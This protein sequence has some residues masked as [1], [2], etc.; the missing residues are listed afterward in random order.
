MKKYTFF[1]ILIMLGTLL[2]LNNC[3]TN[4]A[5]GK[6]SFTAFMSREDEIRIGTE[7]HPRLIK[8]FGGIYK[9]TRL[10]AYV[11]RVGLKLA[12][13]ADDSG[14]KYT[15]TILNSEKVNALA[16][17]GGFIYITR[18]LLA[19][20][21]NEAELAG[22]LAHEIGHVTARHT[23]ERYST[24]KATNLG[25]M[26]LN[27]LS[28]A[29]GVPTG[30][31]QLLGFGAEAALKSYSRDQ[32]LE[33]DMLGVNYLVRAG[34]SPFAMTSFFHKLKAHEKLEIKLK[35]SPNFIPNNIFAT[36]PR[37]VDRIK[38]AV[39][40]ANKFN[41]KNSVLKRETFLKEIDGITFGDDPEQGIRSGRKFIHRD[42][43]ISFEV[44]PNFILFN[45]PTQVVARG[46]RGAKM[47]FQLKQEKSISRRISLEEH[48]TNTWSKIF[49]LKKLEHININGL[50]AITSRSYLNG[51][52]YRLIAIQG[53]KN[54]YFHL[55]F[56]SSPSITS[57][58]NT[59]FRRATYSFR[60]LSKS[61]ADA[62][63]P[64]RIK[65]I[66]T[67]PGDTQKKLAKK[68][69]FEAYRLEWLQTLN[70]LLPGQE[71]LP[72]RSLK[73]VVKDYK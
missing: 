19:L 63:E 56:I 66:K 3:T 57:E 54:L 8:E 51:K 45:S 43:G 17:P 61:E 16:L 34:Y 39:R 70:G 9:N 38:K 50:K 40:L 46:P 30:V 32:E 25:M 73:V 28:S 67:V 59:D 49:S 48:I 37:T 64:L 7:E 21:E 53:D 62:I 5:T 41:I 6:K 27:I 31:N 60:R 36:H 69:P 42:L 33:S 55:I 12:N 20:V 44:P 24:A 71:I 47:I 65:V 68:M 10:Q 58:L 15:F 1:F 18:G 72:G 22:V 35:G 23:A 4:P 11:I 14:L 13:Q 2:G 26:M 29:T 52:D